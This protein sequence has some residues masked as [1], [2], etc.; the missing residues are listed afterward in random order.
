MANETGQITHQMTDFFGFDNIIYKPA[1]QLVDKVFF[2][3]QNKP[4]HLNNL[5]LPLPTDV[6][7]WFEYASIVHNL[8]VKPTTTPVTPDP[9]FPL[10][11][12]AKLQLLDWQ[13]DFENS[14]HLLIKI[15]NV[16]YPAIP[17]SALL[18]NKIELIGGDFVITPKPMLQLH[19]FRE[20]MHFK[21]GT[22]RVWFRPAAGFTT[23]DTAFAKTLPSHGAD[24]PAYSLQLNLR[25]ET[26]RPIAEYGNN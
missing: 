14:S 18:A 9:A 13:R 19:K 17:L 8:F 16:E 15:Q 26:L 12:A 23:L 2:V 3:D 21:N 5:K 25:G 6:E 10:T 22:I 24:N 4:E 20:K 11:T 7:Y 1:Q